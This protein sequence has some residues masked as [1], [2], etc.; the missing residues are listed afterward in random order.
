MSAHRWH[1]SCEDCRVDLSADQGK[2]GGMSE[3]P[4]GRDSWSVDGCV[5]QPREGLYLMFILSRMRAAAASASL[6]MRG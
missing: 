2:S 3:M 5:D 1:R 6:D 4:G